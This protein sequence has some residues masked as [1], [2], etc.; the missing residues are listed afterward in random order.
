MVD[1]GIPLWFRC[2]QGKRDPAAFD[3]SLIKEGI[4]Y[5]HNLFKDKNYNLI[6]LADRWFNLCDILDYINS[7]NH[8]YCIRTK[9]NILIDINECNYFKKV[10]YISDISP[11]STKSIYFDS[12]YITKRMYHTRLAISKS[13]SHNEPLFILTNGNTR[14]AIKHYGYR[15]GSIECIFKNHKTNG[16][17]LESTQTRNIHAFSSLFTL[18][19]IAILWLTVIGADYS[20]SGKISKF[21][22]IPYSYRVSPGCSNNKKANYRRYYSIFNTGLILFNLVFESPHYY[23]LKCNFILYDV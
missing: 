17:H 2:F 5:V 3:L 20:K 7:L 14:D 12:V 4:L 23:N 22:R 11:Q 9:S 10:T 13:N 18:M 8:T 19:N 1:N 6:F 15:F 21:F 16:F